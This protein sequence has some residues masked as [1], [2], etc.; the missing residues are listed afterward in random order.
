[1]SEYRE[2]F[3]FLQFLPAPD[4]ILR[5]ALISILKSPYIQFSQIYFTET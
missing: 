5:D 2:V 4:E 3:A 1:M